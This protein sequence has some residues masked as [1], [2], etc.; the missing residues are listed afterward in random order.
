MIRSFLLEPARLTKAWPAAQAVSPDLDLTQ[1][2]GWQVQAGW[3]GPGTVT[4]RQWRHTV[5]G[6][7]AAA[8]LRPTQAGSSGRP[9]AIIMITDDQWSLPLSLP[10]VRSGPGQ[11][12]SAV[13]LR[14]WVKL[15][16]RPSVQ[17][18]CGTAIILSLMMPGWLV[19]IARPT[20]NRDCRC[21]ARRRNEPSK[22]LRPRHLPCV[23]NFP[24]TGRAG[25]G[26]PA[27]Q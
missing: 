5:T 21:R 24:A 16:G 22:P 27:W 15:C 23:N 17:W 7:P 19:I 8:Q 9:R 14:L 11:P 1:R 12:D 3:A 18:F 13:G 6:T 20:W 4:V 26:Q 2:D 10:A 25:S